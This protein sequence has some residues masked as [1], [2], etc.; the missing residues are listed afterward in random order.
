ME[1]KILHSTIRRVVRVSPIA[2][3]GTK[4]D[5]FCAHCY[6]TRLYFRTLASVAMQTRRPHGPMSHLG[7]W[8]E[9]WGRSMRAR[10]SSKQEIR[11]VT[12]R[13]QDPTFAYPAFTSH[14]QSK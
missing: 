13:L 14:S 3:K 4:A 9:L 5:S 11:A 12:D 10:F 6:L 7:A 1:I 8:I 2:T